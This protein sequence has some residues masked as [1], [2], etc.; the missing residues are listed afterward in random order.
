MSS[1]TG[2]GT[3]RLSPSRFLH[4]AFEAGLL[5]KGLFA[6]AETLLGALLYFVANERIL[7]LVRWLTAHEIT[8]DPQDRVAGF[9]MHAVQGFSVSTQDFYA[10][11]LIG[12]GVLKLVVVALLARGI[13][14]AYP[15]AVVVLGGF[16]LYQ[17]HRYVMHPGIGL[18]LLSLLDLAVIVLTVI[19]YRRLKTA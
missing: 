3:E 13:L 5:L 8:E 10:T 4:A 19:E 2:R 12:H 18:V 1:P 9:L 15:L 11:Y 16:I 17:A 6:G 7:A 14:W